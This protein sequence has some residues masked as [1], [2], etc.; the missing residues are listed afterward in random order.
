M[1]FLGFGGWRRRPF[2]EE[3]CGGN[4]DRLNVAPLLFILVL[5]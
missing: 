1:V 2:G 3:I 4:I 5:L